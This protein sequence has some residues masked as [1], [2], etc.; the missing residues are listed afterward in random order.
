MFRVPG[1]GGGRKREMT[2]LSAKWN[3]TG[4]RKSIFGAKAAN[5]PAV[6]FEHEANRGKT[7]SQKLLGGLVPMENLLF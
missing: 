5:Q 1:P 6:S 3:A 4:R 7:R 2:L